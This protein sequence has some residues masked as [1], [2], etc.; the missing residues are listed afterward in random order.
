MK[1]VENKKSYTMLSI[2]FIIVFI[3]IM[4]GTS[5][6]FFTARVSGV[7]HSA[8]VKSAELGTASSSATSISLFVSSM[9]MLVNNGSNNYSAYKESSDAATLKINISTGTTLGMECTYDLVYT[10]TVV[11]NRS[12]A[13]TNNLKE[14]VINGYQIVISGSTTTLTGSFNEFDLTGVSSKAILVHD[15]KVRVTGKN[16]NGSIQWNLR[17]RYYNLALDQDDNTNKSFGGT[18]GIE[19]FVCVTVS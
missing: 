9:D 14:F 11:Y 4:I 18:I 5:F 2:L 1:K 17:P 15:A 8:T 12:L 7:F 13:N 3:V 6:A 19:H 10:P 16:A